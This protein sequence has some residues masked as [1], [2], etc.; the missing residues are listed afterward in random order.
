ME[1]GDEPEMKKKE[2]LPPFF[3]KRFPPGLRENIE[4]FIMQG[5]EVHHAH[6][7][8]LKVVLRG[9]PDTEIAALSE[10]LKK[11]GLEPTQ[12]FKMNRHD[13]SRK[14]RDQLYLVHLERNT[15]CLKDLQCIRALF[16]IVVKWE[17]YQPRPRNV[18]QCSNCLMFGHGTK[19]CPMA[20]HCNEYGKQHAPE[21]CERM[22]NADPQCANYGT[23]HRATSKSCPKRTEFMEI[24]NRASMQNQPGHKKVPACKEQNFP[25]ISQRRPIPILPPLP[26]NNSLAAAAAATSVPPTAEVPNHPANPS[27]QSYAATISTTKSYPLP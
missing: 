24:R 11:N 20:H 8:P 6:D 2:K 15:T 21:E 16:H 22:E 13:A 27:R 19:N 14:H 26:L 5:F 12:V 23:A 4:F 9:L 18:T 25:A 7:K 1:N 17:R 3:V 10:E